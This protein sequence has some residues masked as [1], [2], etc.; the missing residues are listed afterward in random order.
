MD[1]NLMHCSMQ[2]SDSTSQKQHDAK[3]IFQRAVKRKVQWLTGTE[4][5]MGASADLRKALIKEAKANGY[6]FA[7][8]SDVW[9]AVRKDLITPKSW[10]KGWIKTLESGTGSQ[11]FSDRGII[12]VE[13]ANDKLGLVSVGC[14][15]YMTHG[16]TPKEE[17][18]NANTKLT[19]AI[20]A[21]GKVHGEGRERICFF[22]G[23]TNIPDRLYDVFRGQPFTTLADEL[24]NWENTG[25]G[26]IDVIASY[27]ADKR[28]KGTYWRVQDDKDLPLFTDHWITEGGFTVGE[29]KPKVKT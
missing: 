22:H 28:V 3:V 12:W 17:Y 23:D 21:W 1:L 7:V 10:K 24:K 25:H 27:D 9:I 14:S 18:Y 13:F 5:G 8:Q 16:R 20:G 29:L 15:H 6:R 19:K 4:A 11:N 26:S 2:F